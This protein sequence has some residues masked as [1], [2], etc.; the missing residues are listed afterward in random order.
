MKKNRKPIIA[1]VTEAWQNVDDNIRR[2]EQP[3][4]VPSVVLIW[5]ACL[6]HGFEVHV[7]IQTAR[8]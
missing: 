8:A 1:F 6:Q 7:F 4:G 5:T 2:G 3:G